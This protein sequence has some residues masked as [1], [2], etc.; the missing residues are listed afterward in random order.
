MGFAGFL[1]LSTA[2]AA[3]VCG[4]ATAVD[5]PDHYTLTL[6]NPYDNP[7]WPYRFHFEYKDGKFGR[8][9]VTGFWRLMG[10]GQ[11]RLKLDPSGLAIDHSAVKGMLNVQRL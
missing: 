9:W 1:L 5:A 4:E 10:G 2:A 3:V 11:P 6:E 7:Q 8:N